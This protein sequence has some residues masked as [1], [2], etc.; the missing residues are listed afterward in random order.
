MRARGTSCWSAMLPLGAAH[1]G[2]PYVGPRPGEIGLP[3]HGG[4][5]CA[6]AGEDTAIAAAIARIAVTHA[7]VFERFLD[8]RDTG[9]SL[10]NDG[11][12][13]EPDLS[14]VIRVE[15][16]EIR[17]GEIGVAREGRRSPSVFRTYNGHACSRQP[18]ILPSGP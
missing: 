8:A 7:K 1:H 12:T 10:F 11:R 18:G 14:D 17:S 2:S 6:P 3:S 15:V 4:A 16:T 5:D 9:T 13:N